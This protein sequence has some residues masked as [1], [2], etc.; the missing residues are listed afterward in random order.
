MKMK[1]QFTNRILS[2]VLALVMVVGLLP[3]T[4]YAATSGT[5]GDGVSFTINNGTL[6]ITGSGA[7]MKEAGYER[8]YNERLSIK[9]IVIENGV[10]LPNSSSLFGHSNLT[11]VE[12]GGT[13]ATIKGMNV[14]SSDVSL[15]SFTL[16]EGVGK[17]GNSFGSCT[18]L[19]GAGVKLVDANGNDKTSFYTVS[20]TT[21]TA[22]GNH[23]TVEGNLSKGAV[24]DIPDQQYTGGE[25][26]PAVTVIWNGQT[27][28]SD[29]YTVTYSNNTQPGTATV[30]VTGKGDKYYTGTITK[31]FTIL[32]PN[33]VTGIALQ[34]SEAKIFVGSSKDILAAVFP[35]DAT[36][37]G[38][39]WSVLDNSVA[40]VTPSADGTSCTVKGLTPGTT[41]LTAAAKDGSGVAASCIVTVSYLPTLT[42]KV[43]ITG[44]SYNS[45]GVY[46]FKNGA[47]AQ[48]MTPDQFGISKTLGSGYTNSVSFS[49]GDNKTVYLKRYSDDAMTDAIDL[50]ARL[51]WDTTAPTG[52][53]RLSTG[54]FWTNLVK[55]MGFGIFLKNDTTV[56]ITA[57]DTDSGVKSIQYYYYYE[58]LI[59][60]D[61][62]EN[63][64]AIA[65][66]EDAIGN[67]WKDY[68]SPIKLW[69][70]GK[71]IVYA[72]ITDN[73]GN[74]SYLSSNGFVLYSDATSATT[75]LTTT[76]KAGEDRDISVALNRNTVKAVKCGDT[77]L[78]GA[79]YTVSGDKITLKSAYLDT[80][81]AGEYT[82]TISLNP[83]GETYVEALTNEKPA[84][85]TVSLTVKPR[86]VTVPEEDT[87]S[88][89]Y[90]GSE[91]TYSI[92]S[93]DLYTV[94][95]NQQ[96]NAGTYT[97]TVS[98]KD[99]NNT[100]W[101]DG[102]TG[103]KT[104]TFY[105]DKKTVDL[106]GVKWDYTGPFKYDGLT[107]GVAI[108]E[109][110]MPYG[111]YISNY[112]GHCSIDTGNRQAAA[113]V[114][115]DDNYKGEATLLLDWEIVNNWTPT[116]YTVNG[117]GWMNQDFVITPADGY[118]ISLTNAAS[119]DWNESLTYSAETADGSVTVYLKRESDGTISLAKTVNYKIDKTAPTGK[120]EFVERTGWETF[121]NSIT[122][123][124]FYKDEVTVKVTDI[125]HLSGVGKIEYASA[126]KAMTLDEVKEIADW[127]EYNGSF[128]VSLEDAKKFVY[129]IRITD[130]AGNETYLSTDGVEYDTKTPVISGIENGKTYY[131]TQKVTVDDKNVGAIMLN[132]TPAT[133]NI[134]LEGNKDAAYTVVVT[135]LA[136]NKTTVTVIMKPISALAA[137]ID[138]L[139]KDNVNS[140][141]EQ[142]VDGVIAAVLAVDTTDASEEEKTAL[143]EIAQEAALLEKIIDD[144]KAEVARINGELNKHD[145]STVNS[146]DVAAL[147]QLSKDMK[148]LTDAGNLTQAERAALTE[149]AADIAE[150]QKTI[151]GTTAENDRISGAVEDYNLAAVTSDDKNDLEQL[152]AE[153]NKHLASTNL[154]EKEKEDLEDAAEKTEGLLDAIE[155]AAD[156]TDTENIEKVENVTA[157]NITPEDKTN[158][159]KA[160]ADLEK[161]LEENGGNYTEN[162]KKAIGD[163]IKRI[164]DALEVIGNVEVVEK[165]I[166]MLPAVDT[167]EPDDEKA[168]E[169]ITNALTA[170]NALSAYE[171][172]LVDEDTKASL[173]EL[174]AACVAY[175]IVEGDGSSWT[176]DSDNSITFVVNGL[177]SKFVGIKVDGKDVDKADYE[178]KAG[179]T[180][181]TLK[182]SYLETLKSGEHTITVVY[183]DGSTDGTFK[184]TEKTNVPATGDNSNIWLWFALAFISGGAVIAL[185]VVDRRRKTVNY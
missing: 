84:E 73:V 57:Q 94:T 52:V 99:K 60:D 98:L 118:L 127:T 157:E 104:Y 19:N 128:G 58:D 48:V 26:K 80:L 54:N 95:G 82:I 86:Q 145:G 70:D 134:T 175:D 50:S 116:E 158:L 31:N 27:V 103:D 151:A 72:K 114:I 17:S 141:H 53:V 163:K 105:I 36:I 10:T 150:M 89:V 165:I 55:K 81:A 142:A 51:K 185:T 117:E 5:C 169:A 161:A 184:I 92:A 136:G 13:V 7:V 115:Y 135:D 170:Y 168:I 41:T 125:D 1:K 139:T 96:T 76:Y 181:V 159:E 8:W 100:V 65:K 123:G 83:L 119:G 4:A 130:N 71:Y 124:L 43:K 156:A 68:N 120:V 148:K 14:F 44:S 180:I 93:S 131:T 18:K 28:S 75:S 47:E 183:A 2:L 25:V 42:D 149:G 177:F 155:N 20:V 33:Y 38:L 107:H 167:V 69:Q 162:E 109:S 67:D 63:A 97:V 153:I 23:M 102:T 35:D 15:N 111:A 178:A 64:A 3:M 132:G 79:D 143:K 78:A 22:Y 87:T 106:S 122:F 172:S 11:T 62:L 24:A 121:V 40:S 164:D 88:F 171:K 137:P 16:R 74:V 144:T 152:L 182:G 61:T 108:D 32:E 110:T 29:N 56:T 6:T 34:E 129:F 146:D 90:D 112:T 138:D 9:T 154:T 113:S 45:G 21:N 166:D 140:G 77:A 59:N 85:L 91:Q 46:W 39:D 160:K 147:E 37:K 133:E 49:A 173:N 30:T 179:S 66:L 101:D 126:D 176:E 12:Y 174:A